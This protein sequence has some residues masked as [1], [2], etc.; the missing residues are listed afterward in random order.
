MRTKNGSFAIGM[1][2]VSGVLFASSARAGNHSWQFTE[3]FTNADG[4]VQFIELQ[5]S[6]GGP[7]ETFMAGQFVFSTSTEKLFNFPENLIGPTSNRFLLLGTAGFAALPNAPTPDY[8]LEDNFLSRAGDT[9]V[10]TTWDDVTYGAGVLPH[11]GVMSLD[12]DLVTGLNSP[13]NYAGETG[14]VVAPN[15]PAASTWG[16]IASALA[17][18]IAGSV[19]IVRRSS[20]RA[21]PAAAAT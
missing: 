7:G 1:V 10:Y 17:L 5:E 9:L 11:D 8:I 6:L 12:R 16:L 15:I 3:F 13:T 14:S 2:I 19:T 20:K 18:L 4:T 21:Q